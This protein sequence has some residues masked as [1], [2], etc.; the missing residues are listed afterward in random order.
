MNLASYAAEREGYD[1]ERE[2]VGRWMEWIVGGGE[3][4]DG[5]AVGVGCFTHR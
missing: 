1:V 4:K 5:G 3:E 2:G